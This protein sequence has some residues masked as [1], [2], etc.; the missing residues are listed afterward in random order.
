MAVLLPLYALKLSFMPLSHSV[1]AASPFCSRR[2]A[3]MA[4]KSAPDGEAAHRPFHSGLARSSIDLG[5]LSSLI[6]VLSYTRTVERAAMPVH[7]LVDG[8]YA[9]GTWSTVALSMS[10]KR[11]AFSTWAMA[12]EFS[13]RKTSA[14]DAA[15]SW[16]IWLES[17]L[18]EPWRMVTLTPVSLV[19][20][21]THSLVRVSCWAL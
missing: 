15:P 19:N 6:L 9:A 5:S 8:R 17:S 13:V 14:G 16:T 10:A 20:A 7:L 12:G 2:A 21:S 4:W 11:P 18:S 1:V 3:T